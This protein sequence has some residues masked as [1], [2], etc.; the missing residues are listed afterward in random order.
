MGRQKRGLS[1]Y[2]MR[3]AVAAGC[4]MLG[5]A[6]ASCLATPLASVADK[7]DQIE[8]LAASMFTHRAGPCVLPAFLQSGK[9]AC[10]TV[11]SRTKGTKVHPA[12]LQKDELCVSF[13]AAPGSPSAFPASPKGST[14]PR[15]APCR[16]PHPCFLSLSV[17]SC[18]CCYTVF[19]HVVLYC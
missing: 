18:R 5:K 9:G 16:I 17:S 7:V 4:R 15:I 13:F 2:L 14:V 1:R 10:S 8:D 12:A 19:S 11:V 3:Y 6:A